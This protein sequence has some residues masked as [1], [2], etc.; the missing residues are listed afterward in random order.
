MLAVSLQEQGIRTSGAD[1]T[2]LL[3]Q[4]VTAY[5]AALQVYTQADHPVNWAM[6]QNNLGNTL[7]NQGTRTS[8]ADGADLLAQAVTAYRAALQVRTQVDHPVDWAMTQEN[9]AVAH[10]EISEH[11]SCD[12]PKPELQKALAAIDAALTVFDPVHMSYNFQKATKFRKR[13]LA[14]LDALP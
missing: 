6:M 8:G 11:D 9:I 3:S 7:K 2:D 14:K 13:I 5:R 4:S 12:T 10:C 1:G